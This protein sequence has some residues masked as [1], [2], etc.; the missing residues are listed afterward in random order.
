MDSKRTTYP[1]IPVKAWWKLRQKF[2]QTIPSK[3]TPSYLATVLGIQEKSAKPNVLR[4]LKAVRLIDEDGAPTALASQWRDN[5]SY[6]DVCRSIRERVY[7]AELRDALPGPSIDKESALRW[8]MRSTRTGR[9]AALKMASLYSLLTEADPSAWEKATA[10]NSKKAMPSRSKGRSPT[11]SAPV[12]QETTNEPHG[13]PDSIQ[14]HPPRPLASDGI[15]LPEMRLNLE[16]RI[17]ASVTPEQIDLIFASMAKHLYRH[18][19]E[20]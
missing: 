14:G 4:G 9:T 3:V 5:E 1:S 6:P 11:P 20:S 19:N 2:H 12:G 15:E 10:P 17:D 8:F 18:G 16:I 7:P 13:L